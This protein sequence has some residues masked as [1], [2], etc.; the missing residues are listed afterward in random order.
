MDTLFRIYEREYKEAIEDGDSEERAIYWGIDWIENSMRRRD[1]FDYEGFRKRYSDLYA[2]YESEKVVVEKEN[3]EKIIK[4]LRNKAII[5]YH[6][7]GTIF[8]VMTSKG[9]VKLEVVEY[10]GC[11]KCFFG[12]QV[13]I[14]QAGYFIFGC[15][16]DSRIKNC[17]CSAEIRPDGK[18]VSYKVI[19]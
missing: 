17:Y 2:V 5:N 14:A 1:R 19:K 6:P 3:A 18:N 16:Y 7:I 13:G 15:R 12:K 8:N 11:S 9:N 4:D 10:H